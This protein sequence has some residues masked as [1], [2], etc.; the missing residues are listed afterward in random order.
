LRTGTLKKG[1]LIIFNRHKKKLPKVFVMTDDDRL[2]NAEEVAMKMPRNWGLILRNYRNP[3]RYQEAYKVAQI[4]KFRKITFLV[5]ASWRIA[6]EVRADGVHMPEYFLKS[7]I[8]SPI[9]YLYSK[10]IITASAH[11]QGTIRLAKI[12]N[13]DCVFLSPVK[14]T[15]SHPKDTT[16]NEYPFSA[17]ARL[18]KIRVYALGGV[19]IS[20]QEQFQ[21]L[22]AAGI[23]GTSIYLDNIRTAV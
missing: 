22:G 21:K 2:P 23:A 10:K 3:Q 20:D 4:C 9:R 19:G 16:I 11:S 7:Q 15:K 8:L 5:S 12:V 18:N 13:A 1:I 17:I 14:K 6:Y